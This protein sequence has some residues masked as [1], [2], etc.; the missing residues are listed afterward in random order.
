MFN[1]EEEHNV[2]TQVLDGQVEGESRVCLEHVIQQR[3]T[4]LSKV[5]CVQVALVCLDGEGSVH[6]THKQRDS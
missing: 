3:G 4:Q 5:S 2:L 6:C 1:E